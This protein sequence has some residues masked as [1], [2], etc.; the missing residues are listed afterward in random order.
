MFF[1]LLL[2][3]SSS[4]FLDKNNDLLY[5]NGKEVIL[6]RSRIRGSE[7]L[8]FVDKSYAHMYWKNFP[9]LLLINVEM[10]R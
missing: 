6:I 3:L 8:R 4:G 1:F 9:L 2:V 10:K 7:D 5:R